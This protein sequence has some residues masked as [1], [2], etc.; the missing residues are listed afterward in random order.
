D[1]RDALDDA[2]RASAAVRDIDDLLKRFAGIYAAGR[3]FIS[4][5]ERVA[6][7]PIAPVRAALRELFQ[8][9]VAKLIGELGSVPQS[10]RDGLDALGKAAKDKIRNFVAGEGLAVWRRIV[11]SLPVPRPGSQA[12]KMR[13]A[14][15]KALVD[16]LSQDAWLDA[17]SSDARSVGE[18]LNQA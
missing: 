12:D 15:E 14:V 13:A 16:T 5:I 11:F 6:A 2:I 3:R 7:D 17:L 4:A 9:K 1:L 10:V 18:R 8:S